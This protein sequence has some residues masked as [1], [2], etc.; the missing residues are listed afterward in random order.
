MA[1][2]IAWKAD[3][4]GSI[5][6]FLCTSLIMKAGLIN[7]ISIA[8]RALVSWSQ[9]LQLYANSRASPNKHYL[10]DLYLIVLNVDISY[11]KIVI[12]H[13]LRIAYTAV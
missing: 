10:N 8:S 9:W 6:R 5:L 12:Y 1:V 7:K 11:L 13:R 4:V 3:I 2:F